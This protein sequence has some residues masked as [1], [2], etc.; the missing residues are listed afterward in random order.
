VASQ[1]R[2]TP[3]SSFIIIMTD[4][5]MTVVIKRR[6]QRHLCLRSTQHLTCRA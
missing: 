1:N 5:D 6:T 2:A 3:L 4:V